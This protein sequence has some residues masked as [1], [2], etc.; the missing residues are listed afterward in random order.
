[1]IRIFT[2]LFLSTISSFGQFIPNSIGVAYLNGETS[3]AY[4]LTIVLPVQML[5]KSVDNSRGDNV[6][7]EV[8]SFQSPVT[9]FD[10][11]GELLT[12]KSSSKFT[13][14]L[15]CDNDGGS[16]YRPMLIM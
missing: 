12:F 3:D 5:E 7:N 16:Q 8:V 11:N 4:E 6:A 15:W 14:Q 10:R 9:L 13:V 1:M 2:I